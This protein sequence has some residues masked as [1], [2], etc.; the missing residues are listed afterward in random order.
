MSTDFMS[1]RNVSI[2]DNKREFGS[3]TAELL[4]AKDYNRRTNP[5][6]PLTSPTGQDAKK[7]L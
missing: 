2:Y 7:S 4:F 1:T 3:P 5:E 6:T